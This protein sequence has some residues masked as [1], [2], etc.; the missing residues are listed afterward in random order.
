MSRVLRRI[1]M[2]LVFDRVKYAVNRRS[3]VKRSTV[4]HWRNY[5]IF[6]NKI[7]VNPNRIYL[8]MTFSNNNKN[9][10]NYSRFSIQIQIRKRFKNDYRD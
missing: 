4:L 8:A 5:S 7:R 6:G 1:G 2:A 10:Q 9:V 3:C